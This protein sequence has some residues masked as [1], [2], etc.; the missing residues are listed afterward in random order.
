M[1][2]NAA[3]SA[4]VQLDSTSPSLPGPIDDQP[5]HTSDLPK[6]PADSP[7]DPQRHTPKR[8]KRD[9]NSNTDSPHGPS[10]V[11]D[12]DN[13]ALFKFATMVRDAS[14]SAWEQL[15]A[16]QPDRPDFPQKDIISAAVAKLSEL[17]QPEKSVSKLKKELVK[18]FRK[19]AMFRRSTRP[20]APP[21]SYL[22]ANPTFIAHPAK[23]TRV[24]EPAKKLDTKKDSD[25]VTHD[26]DDEVTFAGIITQP[27]QTIPDEWLQESYK[28][29]RLST[30]DKADGIT[31]VGEEKENRVKGYK[32]YRMIR[33]TSGVL[34]G[35]W[36]YE[37]RILPCEKGHCRLGWTTR[38]SDVETP[39]GFDAYG[40]G[41]RDL[42]GDFVHRARPKQYGQPFGSGDVIGCRIF[43]PNLTEEQ[44]KAVDD[45]DKRWLQFRF[46]SLG[47]GQPPLDSGVDLS[48]H[49]RLEFF[50]N[51]QSMGIPEFF[52]KPQS[53][54]ARKPA[55]RGDEAP[56]HA[57]FRGVITA[58]DEVFP[59]DKR[60]MKGGVYYPS[61]SLF[62]DAIVEV[63]FGPHFMFQPPT[64][65]KPMCD[66]AREAPPPAQVDSQSK[67]ADGKQTEG[68]NENAAGAKAMSDERAPS[69]TD[70][71]K[72]GGGV[73]GI[74]LQSGKVDGIQIQEELRATEFTRNASS[75]QNKL[76]VIS[77]E[78]TQAAIEFLP[79]EA[80][81]SNSASNSQLPVLSS[82]VSMGKGAPEK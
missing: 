14:K 41:I 59:D 82:S 20:E 37:C 54:P 38:R 58:T 74:I 46:L 40:F 35:D 81:H 48:P 77:A 66:A 43:I 79:V 49:G 61:V 6:R 52:T 18:Y 8:Q 60:V 55:R 16:A 13:A 51:G 29:V 56:Y 44:R 39:V 75:A 62:E 22:M 23:S 47:Q 34:E 57:N 10:E 17:Q 63:N 67:N 1:L 42:T 25:Q 72:Q 33:A 45:A 24:R 53:R 76:T 4:P 80:R 78:G 11:K 71:E 31:F 3:S 27:E 5:P 21:D 26:G 30:F 50:K 68:S 19:G 70:S 73:T 65:S 36:Y 2:P 64:G 28:P 32:G 7:S 69:L 9:T 12:E 15:A